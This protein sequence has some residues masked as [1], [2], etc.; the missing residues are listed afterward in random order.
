MF[1]VRKI[2]VT[3]NSNPTV[4]QVSTSDSQDVIKLVTI[5][6]RAPNEVLQLELGTGSTNR[7][8]RIGEVRIGTDPADDDGQSYIKIFSSGDVGYIESTRML[9]SSILGSV[10]DGATMR[11]FEPL[12]LP[13]QID[14]MSVSGTIGDTIQALPTSAGVGGIIDSVQAALIVGKTPAMG[15]QGTEPRAARGAHR[16]VAASDRRPEPAVRA[17]G[18]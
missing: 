12:N 6:S 4:F 11:A 14:Q 1:A 9:N 8:G 17:G 18:Y 16:A 3:G 10:I 5:E 15:G 2:A 7:V 13:G